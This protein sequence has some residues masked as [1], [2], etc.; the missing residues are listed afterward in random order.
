MKKSIYLFT[1]L[2]ITCSLFSSCLNDFLEKPV[3]GSL[4]NEIL[5]D[6]QGIRTLL[7]GAY[8]ALDG[9]DNNIALGG[10][11]PWQA[12]PSNWIYGDIAGGDAHKGS[13]GG[14]QPAINSIASY[15]V[16]PSNGFLNTQWKALYEGISR[17]NTVLKFLAEVEDISEEDR[18][19]LAGQARFLR[20]H[21][22]FELKRMFNMVPWIDET[23]VD[24]NVPNNVD[25]WPNIEA[26]FKF[27]YEN[28]PDTQSE[29]G[30]ANKWAAG[31][32]L[33]KVYL[34]QEKF[35][36]ASDLFTTV[37]NS[38]VTSNGLSYGLPDCYSDM[39]KASTENNKGTV[40][41]IQMVANDGT[42]TIANSNQALMLNYPYNSPFRCCGFYQPTQDLVN[43]FRTDPAT[44]L[45]YI[46]SYNSNP[47]KSD[48]GLLSDDSFTPSTQ[49]LDPRLD[50]TVGR[51]GIPYHDWGYHPGFNWVRDQAY[52][53]PYAPK[54]HIYWQ[55]TAGEFADQ[56]SWA[57]GNA[58]NVKI[59]R[60]ADVL[61]MA[62]EAEAHIGNL[63]LALD[64]VNRVRG[65]IADNPACWLHDYIN[66]AK[67]MEGFSNDLAANYNISRYPD[68]YFTSKEQAMKVIRYERRI[69]LGMEGHRFFDLVRWE[70]A[71][72]VL[73]EFVQYESQVTTDIRGANFSQTD[74][75]YPIPQRQIDLSTTAEGP[76]LE[77]NPG[78]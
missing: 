14:D 15:N 21:Y 51:R 58:I 17:A 13:N 35:Q 42:N 46:D 40:F 63:T 29:V 22:Y 33:A 11:D 30:R 8:A 77:Q 39:F 10:G 71:E 68:G 74:R 7:I 69:E 55:A 16:S 37:I 72:K 32:Y 23:T 61:L 3:Q 44:G 27:A 43:A 52:G 25:I 66:P 57:P 47:V 65:R 56:S 60:F 78:Y 6:E 38:G 28:L 36:D 41:S 50:W 24:K 31:A 64:Y 73:N 59:I 20:G 67:P 5:A 49:S 12:A 1:L 53:G 62:A 26:D 48:M 70:V 9:Q 45:P 54:K 2:A 76:V 19:N 75:Y 34:Y 18:A 4:S